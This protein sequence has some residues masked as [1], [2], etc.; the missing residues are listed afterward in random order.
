MWY[1]WDFKKTK[2]KT[3]KAKKSKL[4]ENIFAM[5]H[6]Q[7]CWDITFTASSENVHWG[8][9]ASRGLCLVLG[10]RK[11]KGP[12]KQ[13]SAFQLWI[14]H[15][16][17]LPSVSGPRTLMGLLHPGLCFCLLTMW[18]Q[19]ARRGYC[20]KFK[21][22]WFTAKLCSSDTKAYYT[23]LFCFLRLLVL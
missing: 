8:P 16:L 15:C 7:T 21:M 19:L 10:S 14:P 4:W 13:V 3:K 2:N 6:P 1:F 18:E 12:R 22:T 17:S 11:H 23:I 20:P 5:R 9:S